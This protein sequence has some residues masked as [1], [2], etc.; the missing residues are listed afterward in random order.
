MLDLVE[1]LRQPS[2]GTQ[3]SSQLADLLLSAKGISC[4]AL[5][6]DRNVGNLVLGKDGLV[7]Q[8][9]AVLLHLDVLSA[10]PPFVILKLSKLVFLL[11][12]S[13]LGSVILV[14]SMNDVVSGQSNDAM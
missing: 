11:D 1:F 14:A 12:L 8:D 2:K 5:L 6:I 10:E 13:H 3:K 7:D 9:G 4:P